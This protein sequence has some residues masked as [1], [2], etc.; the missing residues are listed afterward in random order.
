MAVESTAAPTG[1]CLGRARKSV[2]APP[3]LSLA[4]SPCDPID[5]ILARG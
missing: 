1:L 5:V 2:H 3:T 4:V